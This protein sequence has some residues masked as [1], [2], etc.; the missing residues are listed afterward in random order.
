MT[1]NRLKKQQKR[2]IASTAKLVTINAEIDEQPMFRD[3]NWLVFK[4]DVLLALNY[5]DL[6]EVIVEGQ[7]EGEA[8]RDPSA[9]QL[10]IQELRPCDDELFFRKCA[11]T[12]V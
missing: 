8:Q 10:L 12:N 1:K 5:D 3:I 9:E 11:A 6:E 7:E 4:I 2:K